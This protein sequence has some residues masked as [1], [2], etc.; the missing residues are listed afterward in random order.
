[1]FSFDSVSNFS[2][3]ALISFL[4]KVMECIYVISTLTINIYFSYVM[5]YFKEKRIWI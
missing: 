5:K 3:K 4:N 2:L 1:M